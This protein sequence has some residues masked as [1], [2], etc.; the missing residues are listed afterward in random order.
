VEEVRKITETPIHASQFSGPRYVPRISRVPDNSWLYYCDVGWCE[1]KIR[2]HPCG[3]CGDFDS[4]LIRV[5]WYA[6]KPLWVTLHSRCLWVDINTDEAT[7]ASCGQYYS[8]WSD[9][10]RDVLDA[11]ITVDHLRR[12]GDM[13][14]TDFL[15]AGFLCSNIAWDTHNISAASWF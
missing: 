11:R 6:V 2:P 13:K 7:S 4:I 14:T 8:Q 3:L 5:F 10:S 15:T 9:R 1:L 12:P